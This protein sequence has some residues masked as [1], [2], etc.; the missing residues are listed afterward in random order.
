MI[1]KNLLM[2]PKASQEKKGI[3]QENKRI[4]KEIRKRKSGRQSQK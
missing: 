1:A 4:A 3:R 2:F